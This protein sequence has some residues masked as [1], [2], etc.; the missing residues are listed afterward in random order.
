MAGILAEMNLI[1]F[2]RAHEVAARSRCAQGDHT[3]AY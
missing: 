1:F 2:W 3:I